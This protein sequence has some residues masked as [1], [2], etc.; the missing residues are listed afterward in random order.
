MNLILENTQELLGVEN[1]IEATRVL[2]LIIVKGS[3]VLISQ[4][5]D[6]KYLPQRWL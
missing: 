6:S 2:G 5:L 3:Q 4:I 1:G